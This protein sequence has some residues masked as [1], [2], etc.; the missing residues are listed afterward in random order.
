MSD[1][2]IVSDTL[3]ETSDG[4]DRTDADGRPA[5]AESDLPTSDLP[6]TVPALEQEL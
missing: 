1:G 6:T 4:A 3:T 2:Y 5:A